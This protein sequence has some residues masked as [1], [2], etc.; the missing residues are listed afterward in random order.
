MNADLA[1]I[2]ASLREKRAEHLEAVDVLDQAIQALS[3]LDS[4][5][6]LGARR[7]ALGAQ[8]ASGRS[9]LQACLDLAEEGPR[10]WSAEEIVR[11]YEKRGAP[12][13][14]MDPMNATFSA[15]SRAAKRGFL[16]RTGHGRYMAPRYAVNG[17]GAAPAE[18]EE[19]F[20]FE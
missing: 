1:E 4:P 6:M 3:K 17:D 12:M 15:L 2:L 9:V 10:D 20:I 18:E 11:E 19:E 5:S 14:V 16:V 13:S 7:R 8:T